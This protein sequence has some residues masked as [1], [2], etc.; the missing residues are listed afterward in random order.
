MS[1]QSQC[2]FHPEND[3]NIKDC[4]YCRMIWSE[5]KLAYL[6][7]PWLD[8]SATEP[9]TDGAAIPVTPTIDR[10]PEDPT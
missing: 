9:Y 2:P 4:Y 3:G 8:H 6:S 10:S 5:V 1:N 7:T